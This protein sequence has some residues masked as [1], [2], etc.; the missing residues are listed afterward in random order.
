MQ[1]DTPD[2]RENLVRF[3]HL[4]DIHFTDCGGPPEADLERAVRERMLDD[5]RK[6]HERHGAIDA[7]LVVGDIAARGKPADYVEAASFLDRTCTI[8]GIAAER[9]VCVPGNHDI[10]RDRQGALHDAARFQLRRVDIERISDT[11]LRLLHDKDGRHTLLTPLEA[12]NEFAMRYGCA[13]DPDLLLWKP[14]VLDFGDRRL[15]IHGVNTAWICDRSDSAERDAE[16]VILGLFQL[17]PVAEDASAISVALCHHPLR[18]LRDKELVTPWLARA[19]VLLTGHEH[20][21]G[22]GASEDQRWLRIASGAVNPGRTD[23]RWIPAYN[24]IEL[25]LSADDRL[26]VRVFAR[27]WQV[28]YAEFG[29]DR[30]APEPVSFEVR[31]SPRAETRKAVVLPSAER[32]SGP[33]ESPPEMA[34]PKPVPEPLV[35]DERSMV[36]RVMRASRDRRRRAARK[37]G[38]LVEQE[39]QDGL[40]LDKAVVRRALAE[41]RL[42]ELTRM[43]HG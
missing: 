8:V 14:K 34:V 22:V 2:G 12:Y 20:E 42:A 43:I 6:M 25:E 29:P 16:R 7:V 35:S 9:V 27:S 3:L 24:V 10:D 21:P 26:Q 19:Q 30:T 28:D 13:I 17:A 33:S 11:L 39:Q 18:W 41:G 37:L 15:C 4:S 40:A 23:A 5:I 32:S 31:L 1:L 38:L 36:Y